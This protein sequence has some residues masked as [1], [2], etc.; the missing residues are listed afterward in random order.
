M[1][2]IYYV[3]IQRK[4][5]EALI[6]S[7]VDYD[8]IELFKGGFTPKETF[9]M[10]ITEGKTLY[11]MVGFQDTSN[12]AISE[13]F[14]NLLKKNQISGWKAY[15]IEIKNSN[16]KY[17][18]IQIIGRCGKLITPSE[19]GPYVGLKFDFNSWDKSDLFSPDGTTVCLCNQKVCDIIKRNGI[20]NIMFSDIT[21]FE[22]YSL[23]EK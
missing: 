19:R 10:E 18:G 3:E 9:L 16:Q 6:E 21:T 1:E 12:F 8:Y 11:D 22:S 23:G 14:L 17:Y 4:R 20:T 2:N 5:N 13:K 15:E 7:F